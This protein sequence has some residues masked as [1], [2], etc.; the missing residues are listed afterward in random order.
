VWGCVIFNLREQYE[1]TYA[2]GLGHA[3]NNKGKAFTLFQGLRLAG[4]KGIRN[5]IIIVD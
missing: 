1:Q 5:L 3:Y 2:W 4:L